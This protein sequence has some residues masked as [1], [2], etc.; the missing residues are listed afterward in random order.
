[1]RTVAL[2]A[3]GASAPGSA[4]ASRIGYFGRALATLGWRVQLVDATPRRPSRYQAAIEKNLPTRLRSVLD[5]SGFEGDVMPSVWWQSRPKIDAVEADVA[6]VSVPPFSMLTAA[7]ALASRLPVVIDYRDP[8]SAR[9]HPHGLARASRPLE[10]MAV[11]RA[12]AITFAGHPGFGRILNDTLGIPK[13]RLFS[14]SNGLDLTGADEVPRRTAG[15]HGS[16]LD[17]VFVGHWYGRNGPGVLLDALSRVGPGVAR[18]SVIGTVSPSIDAEL[19]AAHSDYQCIAPLYE[20]ELYHRVARADAAVVTMDY[21]SAVESRIPAK[22]YDYLGVG[23]P[24]IAVCPGDSAL[25]RMPEAAHFHHVDHRD[26]T[27]LA[28]LLTAASADRRHLVSAQPDPHRLSRAHGVATL[29]EVLTNCI[30]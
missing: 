19:R 27:T 8:W 9:L 14:V 20:N 7:V 21:S 23:V 2:I 10:R 22:I 30:G 12:R 1:M 15:H 28:K 17:L 11:R 13:D 4:V 26:A 18:L 29:D 25:L 6:L 16:P 24:V 5:A 3:A